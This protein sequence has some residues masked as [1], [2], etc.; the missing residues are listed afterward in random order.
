MFQTSFVTMSMDCNVIIADEKNAA[1]IKKIIDEIKIFLRDVESELSPFLPQSEISKIN[2]G[3]IKIADASARAQ[4]ILNLCDETKKLS[5]G[6]FDIKK[7]NKMRNIDPCG[8]VKGWV[9]SQSAMILKRRGF[10]N[11]LVE[12]SGDMQTSG[13]PKNKK[14]WAI[15]IRD[16]FEKNRIIKIL[17]LSDQGIATSGTAEKGCHIYNPVD[18]KTENDLISLTAVSPSVFDADRFAT[19]AFAMG[20]RGLNFLEN[21]KGLEGYAIFKNQTAAFTSGFKKFE[22]QKCIV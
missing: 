19:A 20:R 21:K 14:F 12:I 7:N 9:I 16:P 15:G 1:T 2:S 10:N 4:H 5:G 22:T 3:Q 17:N 18:N 8:L 6:Y 13:R 11:F